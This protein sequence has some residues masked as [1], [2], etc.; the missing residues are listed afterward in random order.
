MPGAV[1]PLYH[2]LADVGEFAGGNVL[3]S[4]SDQPLKVECLALARDRR[5][6]VLLAN[7]TG[8]TIPVAVRG[9]AATSVLVKR[10]DETTVLAASVNARAFR[11]SD[12]ERQRTTDGAL[13]IELFPYAVVR[14]DSGG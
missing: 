6:R 12:S 1:F 9:F 4:Q 13:R 3:P 10:L 5:Q 7:M 11:E 2:V 8:E 14:I